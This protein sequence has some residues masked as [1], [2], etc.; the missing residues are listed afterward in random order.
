MELPN[1]F[2]G[3]RLMEV[4]PLRGFAFYLIYPGLPA[5]AN[6]RYARLSRLTALDYCSSE[7]VT[8][9]RIDHVTSN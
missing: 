8:L 1:G 5:W 9:L 4:S 3:W 2:I 6:A 7:L